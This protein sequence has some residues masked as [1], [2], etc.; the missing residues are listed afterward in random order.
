MG[1]TPTTPSVTPGTGMGTMPSRPGAGMGTTPTTPSVTPGTG[2]GTVPSRPGAGM[3]TTPTTPSVTPGSG[4]GTGAITTP[5]SPSTT[6]GLGTGI[7]PP[8]GTIRTPYIYG[9]TPN[10]QS[11]TPNTGN[12]INPPINITPGMPP[13]TGSMIPGMPPATAQTMS[14]NSVNWEDSTSDMSMNQ[15]YATYQ[16]FGASYLPNNSYGVPMGMPLY[17]LY[18]YDNSS[19]LDKDLDYMMELYPR[20]AKIILKEISIACDSL[21]YEGSCM[22]DEYPDRVSLDRIVD[23]IYDKVKYME[24]EEPIVEASSLYHNPRRRRDNHLHDLVTLILLG[25][26]FNRR[27]RHRSRRRW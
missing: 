27:R 13:N 19:D 9:T 3:G 14:H 1:T 17:P 20:T 2:M 22:F 10:T 7:T 16:V 25:E 12:T 26:I 23:R 21:D 5:G 6:P 18:G 4:M 15:N 24:E 8:P 11:S